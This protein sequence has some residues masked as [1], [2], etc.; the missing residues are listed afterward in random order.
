LITPAGDQKLSSG[1]RMPDGADI[2]MA[3]ARSGEAYASD[4]FE[5]LV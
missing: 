4:Q 3:G 1:G 2:L 5:G